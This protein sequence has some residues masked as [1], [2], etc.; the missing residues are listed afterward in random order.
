[1]VVLRVITQAPEGA[2]AAFYI[3]PEVAVQCHSPPIILQRW[4]CSATLHSQMLMG[5]GAGRRH[6]LC[7]KV[8]L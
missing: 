7:L 8:K 3:P 4:K 5:G 2:A 1:M 6:L